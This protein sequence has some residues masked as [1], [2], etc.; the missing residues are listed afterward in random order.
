MSNKKKSIRSVTDIQLAELSALWWLSDSQAARRSAHFAGTLFSANFA[1][2]APLLA[3]EPLLSEV[4]TL[5]NSAASAIECATGGHGRCANKV[6]R[7]RCHKYM[8]I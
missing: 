6:C 5:L 8:E 2:Q 1:K 7:C 3:E 4:Q